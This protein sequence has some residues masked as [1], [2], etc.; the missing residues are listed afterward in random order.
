MNSEQLIKGDPEIFKLIP[1]D[2]DHLFRRSGLKGNSLSPF[3]YNTEQAATSSPSALFKPLSE[4][5]RLKQIAQRL[6]EPDLKIEFNRGGAGAA[7]DQYYVLLSNDDKAVL[8]QFVNA[9]ED[10]LFLLFNDWESFLAWWSGLYATQGMGAYKVVFPNIMET[11]VLVCALH[12][13][14]IYR[15]SYMESMLDYRSGVS[16]SLTTQDF[17]QIL[18]R[19]L[20]SKD[21]RWLLPTMFEI[22]PGLKSSSIAL[23]PEHLKQLEELGFITSNSNEGILTLAERARIMGTEFLS[24]WMGSI[25][26]QATALINGEERNLSRVFLAPTAFANHLFSFEIQANGDTR[27]RH[28]ASTAP[29]L[30]QTLAKWMEALQKATGNVAATPKTSDNSVPKPKFCGQCGRQVSPGEKFCAD[31]GTA[32][33][34]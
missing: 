8:A 9:E 6:L 11:E 33:N 10:L 34:K 1:S 30:T 17:V 24:S 21:I 27:F 23:K 5:P 20:A 13:I 29:E 14:D 7:D 4:S 19:S 25:G 12:C 3:R 2:I 32:V 16:L 26:W 28:Q 18:K 31:C 15:R 22:T